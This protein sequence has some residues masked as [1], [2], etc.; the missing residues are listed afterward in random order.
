L[1]EPPPSDQ[2]APPLP[3]PD[4]HPGQNSTAAAPVPTYGHMPWQPPAAGYGYAGYPQAYPQAYHYSQPQWPQAG[5]Q[6]WGMAAAAAGQ[7]P[8]Y[9]PGMQQGM[10]WA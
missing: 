7:Y 8:M 4:M 6:N 5:V 1:Q 9:P 2:I 3:P 10:Y